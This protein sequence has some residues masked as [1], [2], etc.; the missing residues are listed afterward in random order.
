M[1]R[2]GVFLPYLPSTKLLLR[3]LLLLDRVFYN[4]GPIYRHYD[5]SYSQQP[6]VKQGLLPRTPKASLSYYILKPTFVDSQQVVLTPYLFVLLG[7]PNS[8][9]YTHHYGFV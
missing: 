1:V 7:H 2:A 5:I 3:P 6:S 4:L 8:R 9:S